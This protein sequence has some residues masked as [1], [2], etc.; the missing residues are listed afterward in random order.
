MKTYCCA[1][2]IIWSTFMINNFKIENK[3]S[4]LLRHVCHQNVYLDLENNGLLLRQFDYDKSLIIWKFKN[5]R[6][7]VTSLQSWNT[8][9]QPWSTSILNYC[10]FGLNYK[11]QK[12]NASEIIQFA[13]L[14][15]GLSLSLMLRRKRPDFSDTI[16]VFRNVMA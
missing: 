11:V 10:L 15:A 8:S 16:S 5:K 12:C 6:S 13:L 3:A 1:T 9:L 14:R 4:S 2:S 7:A